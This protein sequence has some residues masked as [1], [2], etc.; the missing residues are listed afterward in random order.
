[1]TLVQTPEGRVGEILTVAPSAQASTAVETVLAGS[2]M[3]ARPWKSLAYTLANITNT[4]TFSVYGANESD[5]SDEVVV[6]GPTDILAAA[7]SSYA[8][9]QAPYSYYRVK[10]VD[11]VA[12]A[13]GVVTLRGIC[14]N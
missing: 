14:K 1:M 2:G 11:K 10:I 3:D 9:A 6:S 7:N 12:A 8:V 13:H 4:I 5:Y